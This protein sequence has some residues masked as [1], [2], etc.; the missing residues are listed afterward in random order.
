MG[1]VEFLFLKCQVSIEA[2]PS[3]VDNTVGGRTAERTS[4]RLRASKTKD[5]LW[6]FRKNGRRPRVK[7][8]R[9]D[10]GNEKTK[11]GKKRKKINLIIRQDLCSP[12]N[13]RHFSAAVYTRPVN[14]QSPFFLPR[15]T[16]VK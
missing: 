8:G 6:I 10:S 7:N 15:E 11:N 2:L 12:A 14:K 13:A 9:R 16:A 3:A 5:A 4:V 1:I